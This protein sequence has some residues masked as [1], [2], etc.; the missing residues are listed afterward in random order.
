MALSTFS[1]LMDHA[2][3]EWL[4]KLLEALRELARQAA[5]N[6]RAALAEM[7]ER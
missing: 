4:V 1:S 6:R 2:T 7:G 3:S 5:K